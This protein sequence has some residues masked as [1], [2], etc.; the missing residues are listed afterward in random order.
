MFFNTTDLH[1]DIFINFILSALLGEL[2]GTLLLLITMNFFSRRINLFLSQVALG[3]CCFIL[4]FIP[5]TVQQSNKY[6]LFPL[7]RNM[8]Y[9]TFQQSV[10]IMIFFLIGKCFG[11]A[12]F[13]LGMVSNRKSIVT[14]FVTSIF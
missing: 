7:F 11:G 3:I 5:K 10:M 9:P 6:V 14:I 12:A 8:N 4:A 2:P 1:G 13:L